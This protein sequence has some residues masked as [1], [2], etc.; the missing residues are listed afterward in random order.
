MR[1]ASIDIGT[2][3][4]LLLIADI[5]AD[6]TVTVV[7]DEQIIARLGKGV[8]ANRRITAE[9]FTRVLGFLQKFKATAEANGAT[10]V[11]ASGTSALRDATNGAE[12]VREVKARIGLEI[13]LLSGQEEAELTY[14][15]AVSEFLRTPGAQRSYAVLDIGGGS[16]ELTIGE[17]G[18]VLRKASLNVGAVRLTE[19]LLKTSPPS[20]PAISQAVSEV[21]SWI[22][23]LP[24]LL[25]TTRLIGVAGTVTT[26]AAIDLNLPV[27]DPRRVNGH[28]LRVEIVE[29][30][31]ET[32][33]TK[34]VRDMI[35]L[36]PQIQL[37]RADIILAGVIV[38]F[39]ALKRFGVRGI[40]ASDR[41]LRYGLAL[42]EFSR[43]T[44]PQP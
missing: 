6:G 19:R 41:G 21:R 27:Y 7:R 39:E 34:S 3:T 43:A 40:T 8:D 5:D 11:V 32:L 13:G 17:E 42:R 15:G 23:T 14:R 37:G 10:S 31:Y 22:A 4:I 26:L 12:F 9:T 25:T 24:R 36:Y 33:R 1:I 28:F 35:S 44:T 30:V 29:Q 18:A 20:S 16:T 38:L 2:N